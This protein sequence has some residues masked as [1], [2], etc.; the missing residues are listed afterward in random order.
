LQAARGKQAR[1]NH[2]C[3]IGT[4]GIETK[5]GPVESFHEPFPDYCGSG[6]QFRRLRKSSHEPN[7]SVK[8]VLGATMLLLSMI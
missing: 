1:C 4:R 7:T 3:F 2:T 5:I 6:E 8:E